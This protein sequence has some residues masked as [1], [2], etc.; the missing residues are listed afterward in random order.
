MNISL[1]FKIVA[2]VVL[3]IGSG[4]GIGAFALTRLEAVKTDAVELATNWLPKTELLKKMDAHVSELELQV[5]ELAMSTSEM[6]SKAREEEIRKRR[7]EFEADY[8]RVGSML[9]TDEGKRIHA[10]VGGEWKEF[11][12]FLEEATGL[13]SQMRGQEAIELVRGRGREVGHRLNTSIAEMIALIE[14]QVNAVVAEANR[15][16]SAATRDVIAVMVVSSLLGLV[17]GLLLTKAVIDPVQRLVR[18]ADKAARGDLSEAPVA[19]SADEIGTLTKAFASML[20]SLRTLVRE[21]TASAQ[22]VAATSS[23]L[24][25]SAEESAKAVQQISDTVQQVAAGAQDQSSSVNEVASSVGQVNQAIVQVAKGAESQVRSV[26]E[27]STVVNGMK[28]SL[29]ETLQAL[30][31]VG[32]SSRRSARSAARGG[33]SVRNV[34]SSMERIAGTTHAVAERI[35]ELDKHSQEIGRILEIIDD[36]AEQTNLLALNAAI[37]AARA[38]EHGRGFAVVADEV[39]KLAERSSSETKAIADLVSQVKQ[40]TDKAVAAIDSGL[41]EVE[42]GSELSQEAGNALAQISSD[43]TEGE[44]LIGRLIQSAQALGEASDRVGKAIDDIVSVAEE[45]TAATEQMAAGAE[46][47]RKAVDAIASV[48]EET[49][50]SVE[51]VSASAEQV[52]ASIQEMATSAESLADMAERLREAVSRFKV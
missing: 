18:A 48:S 47:V 15:T 25:A 41:K 44:T 30:E 5:L 2:L 24:S 16:A 22:T 3:L 17:F 39:R 6:D 32:E 43:A 40:A 35:R 11:T 37:E 31:I 20:E 46:E 21:V 51:E 19:R 13:A 38:G 29:N 23:E 36:I 52:S 14:G 49:A 4:V 27:A 8:G 50:A 34:I 1:R 45:N 12:A 10:D 26:H 7:S 42:T 33:E 9:V 28:A